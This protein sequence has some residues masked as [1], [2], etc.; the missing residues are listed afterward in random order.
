MNVSSAPDPKQSV[1]YFLLIVWE[2]NIPK[3]GEPTILDLFMGKRSA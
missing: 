1:L 2:S 3:C